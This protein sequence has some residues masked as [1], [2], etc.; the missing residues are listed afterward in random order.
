MHTARSGSM[1][2][3]IC[4]SIYFL[5]PFSTSIEKIQC[6]HDSIGSRFDI[7]ISRTI[8]SFSTCMLFVNLLCFIMF[9]NKYVKTTG[10]NTSKVL[11]SKST[12]WFCHMGNCR[13]RHGNRDGGYHINSY[14]LNFQW[15]PIKLDIIISPDSCKSICLACKYNLSCSLKETTFFIHK[16]MY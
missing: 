5:L 4:S 14:K 2:L 16:E 6:M 8:H 7:L 3:H 12:I 11:P 10:T 15:L 13:Y 1:F 9:V